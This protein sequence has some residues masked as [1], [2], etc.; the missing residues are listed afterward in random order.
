MAKRRF[1]AQHVL[2]QAAFDV[3]AG[4]SAEHSDAGLAFRRHLLQRYKAGEMYAKDVATIA[5]Y[6]SRAGATG[7]A[8][9]AVDPSDSSGRAA[10]RLQK[11][12]SGR[13]RDLFYW[14]D[15]TMFDK[16]TSTRTPMRFPM[17]LP[18]ENF[19]KQHRLDEKFATCVRTAAAE[20]LP[21]SFASHPVVVAKGADWT[22]ALGY[23]SD[24]VPHTHSDSFYVFYWSNLLF[25]Q[26]HLIAVV[27]RSDLCRCGCAGQC[28][29]A[30]V[31]RVIVWSFNVLATG[32]WP[33][34]RHDG[35]ALDERRAAL[36]GPLAGGFA[37]ALVEMRADL[38]EFTTALGFKTWANNDKP[39]FCC[40]VDKASLY[41]FPA[42]YRNTRFEPLTAEAFAALVA[43]SLTTVTF[44]KP[45]FLQ[46]QRWLSFDTGSPGLR[47][48][49]PMAG[50][51]AGARV[52][53]GGDVVDLKTLHELVPPASITFFKPGGM[54]LLNF[55]SELF[56]IV[57]FTTTNLALD[58]MH[59]VD[60]GVLQ[61]LLAAVFWALIN[62]NFCGSAK[63]HLPQRH[64]DNVLALN[65]RMRAYY[66]V[67]K[68]LTRIGRL[69]V[70]MLGPAAD[71]R[72][73][74]KAA[75]TRH[76]LGLAVTLVADHPAIFDGHNRYLAAAVGE[77][78]GF[79][80]DHAELTAFHARG[81]LARYAT[82]C[83]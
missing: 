43:R 7:V 18:H 51:E 26:R 17:H 31:M 10:E 39:C 75:E 14:T 30:A 12:F 72:L 77:M 49:V 61:W 29:F 4:P 80:P 6:A 74:A 81:G 63:I 44:D 21:P 2:R 64:L 52:L 28:T 5:Y 50:L 38:L 16:K 48:L 46:L 83:Y 78:S 3:G 36:Q 41:E 68:H 33:A 40:S 60:L 71:P 37:G 25:H 73:H 24:A 66:S 15:V 8:D 65:A 1:A 27:R 35:T 11:V 76:L 54:L 62:G 47:L 79:F 69:T 56:S 34:F 82:T 55:I 53:V 42:T 67:R 59:V 70:H 32:E 19:A 45:S 13:A 22:V 23:F 58:V 20:D 57:G 9:L